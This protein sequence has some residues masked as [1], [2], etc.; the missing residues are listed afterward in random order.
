M[1]RIRGGNG[2]GDAIYLRPIVE[3]LLRRGE[4]VEVCCG[5]PEVF[6]GLPVSVK[7]FDRLNIQVLAHYTLG[8]RNP[9]TNQWQDIC[10]SA[11]IDVPLR[12]DWKV[13][14]QALVD[15]LRAKADGRPLVLVSGGRAP[16]ARTDGFG[17]ELL[18]NREAFD[19]VLA[20]LSDCFMVKV[21]KADQVYPLKADVDLNGSTS[22]SDLLDLG[23]SCD[24]IVGQCSFVI[25]LAEVFDKPLLCVWAA[26]GMSPARH[27]YISSITP[28]KVLS[29]S[30]SKFVMD[31]W[32]QQ[33]IREIARAF[34]QF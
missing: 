31:D 32:P 20:A 25:P 23:A 5:Y 27:Y 24:A 33:K 26:E 1:K 9:A 7:P 12:F 29:K 3:E 28:Q 34:R 10:T 21:G 6:S 8:K 14:N 4:Q 19:A 15:G 16:M 22:V 13:K 17:K 30:S 18:P 11:G 2:L